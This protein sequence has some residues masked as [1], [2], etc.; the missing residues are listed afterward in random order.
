MTKNAELQMS[1]P[2]S[3]GLASIR[4]S[5]PPYRSIII[6]K[7]GSTNNEANFPKHKNQGLIKS[8]TNK[9]KYNSPGQPAN[10][11]RTVVTSSSS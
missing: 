8:T 7:H 10:V 6:E 2:T 9:V 5:L 1:I 4:Q 3:N 11:L